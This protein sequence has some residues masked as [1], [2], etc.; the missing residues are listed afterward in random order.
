MY[1]GPH[2]KPFLS[3][4]KPQFSLS[5]SR[6][7]VLLGISDHPI[8]VDMECKERIVSKAAQERFCL[9]QEKQLDPLL[10]FTRKECAMKLTGLGFN[11]PLLSIDTTAKYEWNGLAYRFFSTERE[12]YLISALAAE[13]SKPMIQLLTPEELL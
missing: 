8:G 2:G 11:L 3:T 9:P 5:H 10:V 12:G 7:H 4:G 6:D 1:F 13:G